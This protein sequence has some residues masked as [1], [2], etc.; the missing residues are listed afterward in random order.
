MSDVHA[1]T[2]AY[3]APSQIP[4][5]PPPAKDR[6]AIKWLR[7]NLFSSV[8]NGILTVIAILVIAY[9]LPALIQWAFID[10]VWKADSLS[11]CRE[12]AAANGVEGSFACW[13]VINE[14]FN[15]FLF[16][17]YPE[18][19]YW[20]P[21]LTFVLM[22]G[23][24]A[25]VLFSSVPR[26]TLI[27][28][29]LYPFVAYWLLWGGPVLPI[30]LAIAGP[31]VGY[32]AFRGVE[33]AM[34]GDAGATG[35][36]VGVLVAIVWWAFVPGLLD[37]GPGLEPVESA[38]M[39]GFM[40]A[41]IIGVTGIA[42]SLPF[43][44]LLAL[45]RKSDL[46]FIKTLSVIFIEFIRGVP[47]ITLLFVASSVLNYFFPPGT[48][49]DLILRVVIMATLFASAYMAEV[50]RGGLAALPSGQYEAADSLGLDYWKSMRLIILPQALKISIPGIVNTFIGLFKDT[51][52]V[53]VIG[54]L[55]PV[56]IIAP[57]RADSNWNGIVWEFYVFVGLF[58]WVFCFG[59]SR[60]SMY[61]EK[62]LQTDRR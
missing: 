40:L 55:D 41:L 62:K 36:V 35:M 60:Y 13:A 21:I 10:A 42:A 20:R 59:M 33:K 30:L 14:R 6:G 12:I 2:V 16:G 26:Q 19:L 45:G 9:A 56:G 47:L 23:A 54:L 15:Q 44:I 50:I 48:A 3:V 32:A 22:F 18:E 24:M 1:Q 37:T 4:P 46:I 17:F 28:S 7:E 8:S 43:G 49:L 52:L 61:L 57:I 51:T 39:G 29:A 5:S 25:P 53:S 31:A 34:S 38:K 58:F 11:Q 27:L